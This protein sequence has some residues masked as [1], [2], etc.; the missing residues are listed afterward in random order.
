M[1]LN[2]MMKTDY[3]LRSHETYQSQSGRVGKAQR[4][5]ADYHAE[6]EQPMSRYRRSLAT[7]G[8]FFFTVTLADR[9]SRLLVEHIERLRHAWRVAQSRYPFETIAV[10]ILPDH[11]HAVW[12]LPGG[13]A[14]FGRRWG[15]I[16]RLFFDRPLRRAHALHKQNC[17]T[18]K[19]HLAT[20]FLGTPDPG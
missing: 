3:G 13:E 10:C 1:K 19:G 6:P 12:S 15:A 18:R 5:H 4:A 7:G 16:K 8:T 14:D 17:Q 20:P 2:G 9:R 11:L